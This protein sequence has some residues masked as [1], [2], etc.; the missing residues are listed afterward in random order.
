VSGRADDPKVVR[1]SQS[2]SV[3][4]RTN[5]LRFSY[6]RRNGR[7]TLSTLGAP[8]L[9]AIEA[10][11][12]LTLVRPGGVV[13]TREVRAATL[14]SCR[15][16]T[17][18][19]GRC[20]LAR[21]RWP[22]GLTITQ[23]FQVL[24]GRPDLVVSFALEAPS[25]FRGAIR[26]LGALAPL[27]EDRP[28][29]VVSP[30]GRGTQL[31]DF[32]W[33]AN[34]PVRAL[35]IDVQTPRELVATGLCALGSAENGTVLTLAFGAG[36]AAV[37]EYRFRAITGASSSSGLVC[38]ARAD[39]GTIDIPTT[40]LEIN[41]LWL[42]F[43]PLESTLRQFAATLGVARAPVGRPS[44]T[45]WQMP[46][47]DVCPTEEGILAGLAEAMN[48][49]IASEFDVVELPAGWEVRPSDWTAEAGRFPHG[50]RALR[51]QVHVLQRRAGL[52]VAPFAV[53]PSADVVHQH[54]TWLVRSDDGNPLA[55]SDGHGGDQ[56]V[57]D[58]SQPD[59]H[60]WLT[61]LGQRIA[62][63]WGFDLV[64]VNHLTA[65]IQNG[66]RLSGETS[67]LAASWEGIRA[68]RSGLHGKL[69]VAN[70]APLFSALDL[71][72]VLQTDREPLTRAR[73]TPLTRCFLRDS[74]LLT[75]SGPA[76]VWTE[77]Q[78]LEEARA[79]ATIASLSGG[80]ATLTGQ[81]GALPP[82]RLALW[83]VCLP[84]F[85]GALYPLD[86]F[87]PGGPRLFGARIDQPWE[88]WLLVVA[89]NPAEVP[90][91]LVTTLKQLGLDG[92]YHAFEF[93]TQSY[94]GIL[95]ER[96]ALDRIPAGGCRVVALRPVRAEPQMI[97]TSL[98]VSLGA[99][100]VH[101]V[102]WNSPTNTLHLAVGS[103]GDREGTITIHVPAGWHVSSVRGT[104]GTFHLQQLGEHLAAVQLRFRQ[105][106]DV[107]VDFW[108]EGS[109]DGG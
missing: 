14:Q 62:D 63:E 18:A 2:E 25:D 13:Q 53:Q 1:N 43:A 109:G 38:E 15:E 29:L 9:I 59:V 20:L 28:N 21:R 95:Q 51:D 96:L 85:S 77:G 40:G 94:L 24:D 33:T 10:L 61:T 4:L 88:D 104:G 79:A 55:V 92:T 45:I 8:I 72:D 11:T 76:E 48:E 30:W 7:F 36:H 47:P 81:L 103:V 89:I 69:L 44:L 58:P 34:E 68:L 101:E 98:H 65:E 105:V 80:V 90:I 19:N 107:Q 50:L 66:W 23:R 54:P 67:P 106:A 60:H 82:E 97:G 83:Q 74:G 52:P 16:E 26:S 75:T 71:V 41:P 57:L 39:L 73:A 12:R 42:S 86:A 78:T 35:P 6:D 31:L 64:R 108:S 3:A 102:E 17:V 32:G 37:G 100:E 49:P 93:W 99:N 5:S 70:E 22:D 46:H 84:P 87:A 56:Y 27:A 91:A